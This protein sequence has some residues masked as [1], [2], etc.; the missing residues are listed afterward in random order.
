[1]S[2]PLKL[3]STINATIQP[4]ATVCIPVDEEINVP[5]NAVGK[6]FI[7]LSLGEKGLTPPDAQ[8]RPGFTGKPKK[9]I[10]IINA[11]ANPVDIIKGDEVG[12]VYMLA[13]HQSSIN[14]DAFR[15]SLATHIHNGQ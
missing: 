3:F 12:E 13:L 9:G 6:F 8:F 10:V 15:T 11:G 1:M 5:E 4:G 7:R 14:E 2:Q